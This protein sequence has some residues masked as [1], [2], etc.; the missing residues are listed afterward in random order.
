MRLSSGSQLCGETES[1][2]L[3]HPQLNPPS[4]L[5]SPNLTPLGA[6]IETGRGSP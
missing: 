6:Y 4:P 3:H 1:P 2:L 5:P